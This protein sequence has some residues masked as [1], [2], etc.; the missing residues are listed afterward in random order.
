MIH[1]NEQQL[2]SDLAY[3][4]QYLTEFMGF[5][6]ED[7]AVVHASASALAPLVPS[8]VNAVYDQ[9]QRYDA[10]WRHFLPRQ[11]GYEGPV[12]QN[13]DEVTQ[14]HEMI[15]FRKG[16]LARYLAG[17]VTKPYDGKLVAYLDF[18]GKMHTA[19]AGSAEQI[20]RAHV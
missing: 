13:L 2:E 4:F 19:K 20:G 3:R 9:L 8:L 16:H 10:T 18:V 6:A 12:P 5:N 1:I 15:Q 17:L 7:I 11:A 14:E